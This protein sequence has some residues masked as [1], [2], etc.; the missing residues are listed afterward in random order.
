MDG[1]WIDIT[2]LNISS[3][4]L[5]ARTGKVPPP[6]AYIE[7]RRGA[8]TIVGKVVWQDDGHF[9]IRT[10]DRISVA[11]LS[12]MDAA[13]TPATHDPV[14][15]RRA[16]PRPGQVDPGEAFERNRRKAAMIQFA[17]LTAGGFG[18]AIAIG[19]IVMETLAKPLA[20]V[21]SHLG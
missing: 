1:S 11:M 4:G 8:A 18:G 12:D 3:R 14:I 15:E 5:M 19:A 20:A 6:R 16:Q 9:G 2:I 17:V 13:S 10:Q 21:A 7:I